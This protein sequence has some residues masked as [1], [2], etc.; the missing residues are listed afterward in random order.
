MMEEEIL[1]TRFQLNVKGM[2]GFPAG[3]LDI[4]GTITSAAGGTAS[5]F[6]TIMCILYYTMCDRQSPDS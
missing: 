4:Q 1:H 3:H 6:I 5:E 2:T